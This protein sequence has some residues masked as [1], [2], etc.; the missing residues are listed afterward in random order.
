[1]NSIYFWILLC[2]FLA[3]AFLPARAEGQ[4]D[5]D[6]SACRSD[7]G[8]HYRGLSGLSYLKLHTV[9]ADDE[10]YA[11]AKKFPFSVSTDFASRNPSSGSASYFGTILMGSATHSNADGIRLY[12]MFCAKDSGK[13]WVPTLLQEDAATTFRKDL[14]ADKGRKQFASFYKSITVICPSLRNFQPVGGKLMPRDSVLF[15]HRE[16]IRGIFILE[17]DLLNA[18]G[19]S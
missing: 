2:A 6:S 12:R 7:S 4:F 10:L 17:P 16:I 19:I 13:F 9:G 1:M 11:K 14:F 3:I 18:P 5:S 15:K 8:I